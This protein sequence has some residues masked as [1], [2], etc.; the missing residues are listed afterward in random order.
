MSIS[1][2]LEVL[3]ADNERLRET[4]IAQKEALELCIRM[5]DEALP[6]F[7]WGKSALDCNAIDLLNRTPGAIHDALAHTRAALADG[8]K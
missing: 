5:Y 3:K 4:V 1:M 8:E 7:D 6:K 2:E